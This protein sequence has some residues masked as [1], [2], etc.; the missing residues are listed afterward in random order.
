M[1]YTKNRGDVVEDLTRLYLERMVN[2]NNIYRSLE[3]VDED[4]ECDVTVSLP[5]G[6]L[7]CECKSKILTLNALIG[8]SENNKKDVYQAI[9]LVY[10][11]RI[12]TIKRVQN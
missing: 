3:Y 5:E 7:F 12:R 6:T 1:V 2:K 9:G 10:N 8:L 11:Q 4:G